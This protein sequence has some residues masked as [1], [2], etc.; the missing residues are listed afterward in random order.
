MKLV[1]RVA[2]LVA[3]SCL[4]GCAK[5]AAP[6][7]SLGATS[8]SATSTTTSAGEL[9]L[10]QTCV[11][12]CERSHVLKCTH[13]DQCLTNCVAAATGTPCN[14]EFKGFYGCIVKEPIK[15]W[16]CAEDGVA[17]IREGLCDAEQERAVTCMQAKAS[18]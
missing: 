2:C 8:A 5:K 15:N 6:V 18:R 1:K 16:E 9:D 14:P 11:Q 3:V 7:G 17:S 10:A 4:S 12:I 13:A